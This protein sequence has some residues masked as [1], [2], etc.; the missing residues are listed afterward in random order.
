MGKKKRVRRILLWI[1]MIMFLGVAVF[2]GLMLAAPE[3]PIEAI[4]D[5]QT[6]LSHARQAEAEKYAPPVLAEA[7]SIYESANREWKY[8]NERWLIL[9]NYDMVLELA[10]QAADKAEEAEKLSLQVRGSLQNDLSELLTRVGKQISTFEINYAQLPLNKKYRQDFTSAKLLYVE[11]LKSYERE[12]FKGVREKLVRANQLISQSIQKAHGYLEDY[13][14]ALPS[15]KKWANESI[16]W[17]KKH[18]A[19]AIV[20]DKFDRKCLVYDNGRLNKEFEIELGPNWI[21]D[22]EYRGDGATPE[23]MYQVTRK[24]R[25]RE[26]KY[27][28]ALLINYPNEEDKKQ[29]EENVRKGLVPKKGIGSLIEIHG[30]GGRGINWTD[31]CIALTND[32]MDRLYSMTSTG[33]P[34]TIVGSLRSLNEING[35]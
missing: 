26:T 19:A 24:K 25:G 21:G 12:E 32:D 4:T 31:G 20:I 15:W 11:C 14:K 27:Y 1:F 28:K 34:V 33:T 10:N 6:A 29:Y 22:K 17:S 5:A 18:N 13:F 35:Y 7:Q 2:M 30:D 23:G 16:N 8:Q 9:R 3:P